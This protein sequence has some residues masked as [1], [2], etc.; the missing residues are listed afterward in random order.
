MVKV[1]TYQVRLPSVPYNP[2]LNTSRDGMVYSFSR[3]TV[4]APPTCGMYGVQPINMYTSSLM[5]WFQTCFTFTL[6]VILL[7]RPL[8]GSLGTPGGV[9][10]L[11]RKEDQGKNLVKNLSL[12]HIRR[13]KLS[14]F[15]Y[16]RGYVLLCLSLLPS[17]ISRNP[18]FLHP[19]PN[20]IPSVSCLSWSHPC[21]PDISIFFPGHTSLLLLLILSLFS[22]SLTSRFLLSHASFLPPLPDFLLWVME[23]SCALEIC[24]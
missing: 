6:G 9:R 17:V 2:A 15:I 7:P 13:S 16:Q 18:C 8:L 4:P 3:Q 21:A 1:V 11:T 10:S 23:S 12:L 19:L 14:L 5:R 22:L 24:S 20:S